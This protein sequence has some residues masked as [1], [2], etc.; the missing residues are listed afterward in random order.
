MRLPSVQVTF[1]GTRASFYEFAEDGSLLHSTSHTLTVSLTDG[2][3]DCVGGVV[4]RAVMLVG[5][6][7]EGHGTWLLLS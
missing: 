4:Q 1:A 7:Y 2:L 6:I 3:T 5:A